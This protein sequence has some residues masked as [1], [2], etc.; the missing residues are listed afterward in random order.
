MPVATE[1]RVVKTMSTV[2]INI[3]HLLYKYGL[4][5][6]G[7]TMYI[8]TYIIIIIDGIGC[9]IF[10]IELTYNVQQIECNYL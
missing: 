4:I 7:D 3:R 10:S 2:E 1:C 5:S 8:N 9:G 6:A